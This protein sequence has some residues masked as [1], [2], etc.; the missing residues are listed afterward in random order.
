MDQNFESY[1]NSRNYLVF[2]PSGCKWNI[3]LETEANGL[4]RKSEKSADKET[5]M[6][7][8]PLAITKAQPLNW[9]YSRS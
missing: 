9:N 5:S 2:I 4:W 8:F 7:L 6:M 3:F 1:K